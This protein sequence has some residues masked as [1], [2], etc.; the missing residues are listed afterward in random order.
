[1]AFARAAAGDLRAGAASGLLVGLLFLARAE[2]ALFGVA[3]LVLALRPPSRAA[4]VAGSAVA[5]A[6]GAGWL[7]RG[8]VLGGSPDLL[9]RTVLLARYEDFFAIDPTATVDL[10]TMIT[11]RRRSGVNR[12]RIRPI[13]FFSR[14]VT[15]SPEL[16]R[17][18]SA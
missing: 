5:L 9:A 17:S 11:T 7:A 15:A 10:A 16:A 18:S 2:G 12:A 6:I 1:M 8:V 3:L 14:G 13:P 4:G